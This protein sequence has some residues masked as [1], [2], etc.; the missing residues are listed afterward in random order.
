MAPAVTMITKNVGF[1]VYA[2]EWQNDSTV[3][4]SGG[5]GVGRFGVTNKIVQTSKTSR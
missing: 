3:V 4:A 1:P 5:G 2:V